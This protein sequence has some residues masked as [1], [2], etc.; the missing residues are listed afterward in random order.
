MDLEKFYSESKSDYAD[1]KGRLLTDE[2]IIKFVRLFMDDSTFDS[3]VLAMET[4]NLPEAFRMAHTLK[5]LA[6]NLG[7]SNLFKAASALTETLRIGEDGQPED[8]EQAPVC[9]EEV[10]QAYALIVAALPLLND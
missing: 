3:L 6:G 4:G 7:F 10:V 1:V 8:P 5:G 9:M 2:R